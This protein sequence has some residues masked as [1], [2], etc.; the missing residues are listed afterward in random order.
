M[1]RYIRTPEFSIGDVVLTGDALGYQSTVDISGD[2]EQFPEQLLKY[3][4]NVYLRARAADNSPIYRVEFMTDEDHLF[5]ENYDRFY[6]KV[7]PVLERAGFEILD[8]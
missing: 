8:D 2:I 4:R 7:F 5:R 1:K 3:V 6:G